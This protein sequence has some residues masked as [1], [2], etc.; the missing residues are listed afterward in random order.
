MKIR[1]I[2][3]IAVAAL[4]WTGCSRKVYVPVERTHIEYR[5]ADSTAMINHLHSL[6]E[7]IRQS[8]RSTDSV[9]E[10]EKE[11]IVLNDRGDTVKYT[12][13]HDTRVTSRRERELEHRVRE[14]DSIINEL[15]TRLESIKADSISVP[16]PVEVEKRVEVEKKLSLWTRIVLTAGYVALCLLGLLAIG[17]GFRKWAQSKVPKI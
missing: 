8:E 2:L 16:Y 11:I 14:Q 17:W 15:Q 4:L 9:I 3:L 5:D 10:K 1:L 12:K 7:S 6:L 13:D